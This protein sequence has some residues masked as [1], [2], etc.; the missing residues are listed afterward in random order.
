ML[1]GAPK[2]PSHSLK[3]RDAHQNESSGSLGSLGWGAGWDGCSHAVSQRHRV[4]R[5]PLGW[6]AASEHRETLGG[7][8]KWGGESLEEGLGPGALSRSQRPL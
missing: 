5:G 8:Q 1:W 3:Y 4:C 6:R 2:T 7:S